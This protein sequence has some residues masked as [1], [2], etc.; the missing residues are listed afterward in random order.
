MGKKPTKFTYKELKRFY[1]FYKGDHKNLIKNKI[2]NF[3]LNFRD[4]PK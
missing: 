1:F 4:L 2:K 3:L